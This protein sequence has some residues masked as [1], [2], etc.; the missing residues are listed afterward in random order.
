MNWF[1]FIFYFWDLTPVFTLEGDDLM[2]HES[3]FMLFYIFGLAS[4]FWHIDSC[5]AVLQG[6]M[7][8]ST[9]FCSLFC[10]IIIWFACS[11]VSDC[12]ID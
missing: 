1:N 9:P 12:I 11:N 6:V 7:S 8:C 5:F 4:L 3:I 2:I 10:M